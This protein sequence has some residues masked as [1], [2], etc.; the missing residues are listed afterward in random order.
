MIIKNENGI[1]LIYTNI[2][3][4]EYHAINPIIAPASLENL[5]HFSYKIHRLLH[6]SAAPQK[7][8]NGP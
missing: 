7:L 3:A 6:V 8:F 2:H 5:L 1:L 4:L